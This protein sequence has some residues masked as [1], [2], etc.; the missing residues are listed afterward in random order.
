MRTRRKSVVV[1]PRASSVNTEGF[2]TSTLDS[3]SLVK[4]LVN[5]TYHFHS[6]CT[7]SFSSILPFSAN[8]AYVSSINSLSTTVHTSKVFFCCYVCCTILYFYFFTAIRHGWLVEGKSLS[9]LCEF[10]ILARM[11]DGKSISVKCP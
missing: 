2:P 9:K 5:A 7:M 6:F 4:V 3:S 11:R 10:E 1:Q 8:L